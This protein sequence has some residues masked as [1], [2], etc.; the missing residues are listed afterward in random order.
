MGTK[1]QT[2]GVC[3][4][5]S[6]EELLNNGI[7][8]QGS[9]ETQSQVSLYNSWHFT[10]SSNF[11]QK[12]NKCKMYCFSDFT[13]RR[14]RYSYIN[15]KEMQGPHFSSRC[16]MNN[17]WSHTLISVLTAVRDAEK[18]EFHYRF[19]PQKRKTQC[20]LQETWPC[21]TALG[22]L[23]VSVNFLNFI[24]VCLQEEFFLFPSPY[25]LFSD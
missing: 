4:I 11:L 16:R 14:I 22:N 17:T 2:T 18:W 23:F 25:L 13:E 7:F 24:N 6:P 3:L 19:I 12:T 1:C 9:Q 10:A 8:V 5:Q 21:K 20:Q 15:S